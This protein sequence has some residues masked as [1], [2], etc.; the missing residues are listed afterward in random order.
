[1][2]A[3]PLLTLTPEMTLTYEFSMTLTF[4]SRLAVVVT[5]TRAKIKVISQFVQKTA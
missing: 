5:D 1:M 3:L 2:I 4:N